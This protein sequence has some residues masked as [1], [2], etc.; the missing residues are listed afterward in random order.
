MRLQSCEG[1]TG[2]IRALCDTGAQV[3]LITY[4]CAEKYNLDIVPTDTRIY[5]VDNT[6]A[7]ATQG[8]VHSYLYKRHAGTSP[9]GFASFVVVSSLQ[10][11]SPLTAIPNVAGQHYREEQLADPRFYEPAG[12]EIIIGAGTM[13]QL[14]NTLTEE[15]APG[16]IAQETLLGVIVYGMQPMRTD[17]AP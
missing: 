7:I 2:D 12:I 11:V 17:G 9:D 1:I 10:A 8:V 5:S 13:A 6:K 16:F 14:M 4:K 3:N 15:V